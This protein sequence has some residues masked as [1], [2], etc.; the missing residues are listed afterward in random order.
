MSS[1]LIIPGGIGLVLLAVLGVVV[2]T[3]WIAHTTG[4]LLHRFGHRPAM[5]LAGRQLMADPWSGSRT[6]AALL[7][8]VIVGAGALGYRIS[9]VTGFAA[10][11][12]ANRRA[13]VPADDGAGL[14]EDPDFYLGAVDM[15]NL[16]VA[17]A[18][19]I[20]A[21]GIMVALVEGIVSRRRA[22]AALVA[23]GVPRR[24]LGE[25]VAWQTLA[26]LVP[27]ILVALAVGVSM[28]RTTI[29]TSVTS[30]SSTSEWCTGTEA[31]CAEPNSTFRHV[32]EI[33][34][35]MLPIP[36]PL[37]DLAILGGATFVAMLIVVAVGLFF[38]RR[39]TDLEEL[40]VG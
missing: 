13:G 38:L 34:G 33:G 4:R 17:V 2:G 7:A 29:G 30:G 32:Q 5:M 1:D 24:T 3:G 22:Y 31:Q 9:M 15:V 39:S 36:V 20:A 21:V 37:G 14:A 27:A 25:A 23:T 11:V 18:V 8:G 16:A 12:E 10:D 26:P 6:F 40:R 35:V 19:G 28:V